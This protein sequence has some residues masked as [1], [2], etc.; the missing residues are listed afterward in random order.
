[1]WV[2]RRKQRVVDKAAAVAWLSGTVQCVK[3][4]MRSIICIIEVCCV[5][6]VGQR[7]ALF[8]CVYGLV[9]LG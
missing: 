5:Y 9:V 8:C 4:P 2:H 7:R 1:M 6:F 3:A